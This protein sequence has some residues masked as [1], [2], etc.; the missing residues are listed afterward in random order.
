MLPCVE[1]P[2]TFFRP[3]RS[4]FKNIERK[5]KQAGLSRK[6][7]CFPFDGLQDQVLFLFC[8]AAPRN[9]TLGSKSVQTMFNFPKRHFFLSCQPMD[10]SV[11]SGAA[12]SHR[13]F[14]SHW[15]YLQ[16]HVTRHNNLNQVGDGWLARVNVA[17]SLK[18]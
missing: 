1:N 3:P 16:S 15:Q 4:T 7:N 13:Y 8:L 5:K 10:L 11:V 17:L 12:C 14:H 2:V 18:W 9:T 6:E